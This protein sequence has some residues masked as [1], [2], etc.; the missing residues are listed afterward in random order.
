MRTQGKQ[1]SLASGVLAWTLLITAALGT[2][3][4]AN[5]NP[6]FD[7][8]GYS[9]LDGPA[10]TA[11]TVTTIPMLFDPVQPEPV[12]PLDLATNEYTVLVSDLVIESVQVTGPVTAVTYAGGTIRVFEDPA[13]NAVWQ[14]NPPNAQVPATFQDGVLILEGRVTDGSLVWNGPGLSGVFQGHVDFTGGTKLDQIGDPAQWLFFGGTASGP[15]GGEPEG[16]DMA[17]DPQLLAPAPVATRPASWGAIK[18]LY[19]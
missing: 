15:F 13:R 7:F 10:F 1:T 11:G 9:Y 5:G 2:W 3:S 19:R 12:L 18:G 4:A 14:W 17:W 16:Y 8:Y 6:F